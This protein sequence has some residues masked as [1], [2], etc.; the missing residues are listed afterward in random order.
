[1]LSLQKVSKYGAMTRASTALA[2]RGLLVVA[3][4]SSPAAAAPF[5]FDYCLAHRG[6]CAISVHH[7]TGG[8]ERH[9]NADRLQATGSTFKILSLIVYAQAVVDGRLDPEQL[10]AKEEWARF[11]VGRDGGALANAWNRL[12]EP[13]E[14]TVDQMMGAMIRESDNTA[15]DWLLDTLG[16][17]YFGR[18]LKGYLAGYHD[19]PESINGT[20]VTELG[21]PEDEEIGPRML[22]QYSGI[23][24]LGFLRE[25]RAWFKRLR[26]A[27]FASAARGILCQELPWEAPDPTCTAQVNLSAGQLRKLLGGYFL[28]SNTRTYN[29]LMLGLLDE[30]LLPPPVQEIVR[31]HLEWQLEDPEISDIVT[32]FGNKGG[33]LAPQNVCNLTSYAE[34]RD[35]G[36]QV[37]VTVFLHNVPTAL[38][39]GEDLE[40]SDI[41]ADLLLEPGFADE[42]RDRMPLENLKP[43]LIA[44]LETLRRK[45][46]QNG[47]QLKAKIRVRNIGPADAEG[48]FEISLVVSNDTKLDK[49]DDILETWIIPFLGAHGSKRLRFRESG[50]DPLEGKYLFVRV[51]GKKAVAESNERN[52]R[53]PWQTI[54]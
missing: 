21:N 5:V 46:K 15:P 50:L 4:L 19:L 32:R 39:C 3:L 17:K 47:D 25:V 29:R 6:Q 42:L 44:R 38:S 34:L 36:E 53:R 51:D 11:S 52:N 40:P 7:V 33:S 10:V 13:D 28:Q 16:R 48:P 43:D 24:A 31:R 22:R 35:T 9:L 8:W 14:V 27:E 30:S 26:N 49:N 54:P 45:S 1:M 41:I 2:A 12:G 23:D 20:F 37:V 18:V